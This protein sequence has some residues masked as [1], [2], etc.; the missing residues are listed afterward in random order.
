MSKVCHYEC[1]INYL[2]QLGYI[3]C[4]LKLNMAISWDV[5]RTK[6]YSDLYLSENFHG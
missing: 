3:S 4:P 1:I 6:I 2:T 5:R